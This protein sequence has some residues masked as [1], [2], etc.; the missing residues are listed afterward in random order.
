[1]KN[2]Y[3]KFLSIYKQFYY[4]DLKYSLL[5]GREYELI[6]AFM[7]VYNDAILNVS[8]N[9]NDAIDILD[10]F[11]T[12]FVDEYTLRLDNIFDDKI[13]VDEIDID[14]TEI[15]EIL[16]S[17]DDM[18]EEFIQSNNL[19]SK[20]TDAIY[21]KVLLIE[22]NNFFSHIISS[23]DDKNKSTDNNK[24]ANS[25]L[26]RACIDGYKEILNEYSKHICAN[27]TIRDDFL[28]TR[29][30][31]GSLIGHKSQKEKMNI[32]QGYKDIS[33]NLVSIYQ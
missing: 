8:I 10:N 4:Y 9:T 14:E 1:M 18:W 22:V 19:L 7:K 17:T 5:L 33:N 23:I 13:V 30:L 26:Y 11:K 3:Y 31:E 6:Y 2:L 15:F 27:K 28:T 32:V 12:N 21:H 25:H 29:I 16:K 24:R 20:D